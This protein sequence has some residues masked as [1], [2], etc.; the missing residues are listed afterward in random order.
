[1]IHF[2]IPKGFKIPFFEP[3]D[4]FRHTVSSSSSRRK[5][6]P[7]KFLCRKVKNIILYRLAFFCPSNKLRIWMHRHR[8]CHIGNHVYI[9][10]QCTIDNAYPE[11][12]Y[13]EDYAGLTGENSVLCHTNTPPYFDGIVHCEAS[14]VV[15]RH[16]AVIG[17]RASLLP[18]VEVG[19][20]AMVSAGSVVS[21]N[22][23]PYTLVVGVP[24]R[25]VFEYKKRVLRNIDKYN[26]TA[27]VCPEMKDINKC[28]DN[29][30]NM[31]NE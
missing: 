10:Q 13:I 7:L 18:G 5:M 12:F 21:S 4:S 29:E 16:H 30:N 28:V 15:V 26:L 3:H 6:S 25:K 19:E 20:Y 17:G 2:D 24:A 11:L 14:P 8:G 31:H 27:S 9:G 1:M 23:E 22:V